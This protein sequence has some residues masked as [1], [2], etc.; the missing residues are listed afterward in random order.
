MKA[1]AHL[2]LGHFSEETARWI[3]GGFLFITMAI[4]PV[5][6]TA[7]L[8]F[9]LRKV[10]PIRKVGIINLAVA[11]GVSLLILPGAVFHRAEFSWLRWLAA[12]SFAICW[13]MCG[14]GLLSR[15]R[16]AWCGSIVGSGVLLCFLVATFSAVLAITIYPAEETLNS[17]PMLAGYVYSRMLIFV[18]LCLALTVSFWLFFGLLRIRRDIFSGGTT[19]PNTWLERTVMQKRQAI[20]TVGILGA[21]FI[22]IFAGIVVFVLSGEPPHDVALVQQFE[23]NR[24]VFEELRDM[25]EEDVRSHNISEVARWGLRTPGQGVPRSPEEE[26]MSKER[27]Q[28]YLALMEKA[29]IGACIHTGS[30]YRFTVAGSGFAGSGFRIAVTWNTNKPSP[31]IANLD[32]FRKNGGQWEQ[33]YRPLQENWYLWIIW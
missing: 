13:L 7:A 18:S 1:I 3:I 2:V 20:R 5:I 25:L 22:T 14:I 15:K 21:V 12:A 10:A 30:D 17:G 27:Y 28:K 26:G 6:I 29:G 19:M 9:G 16:I 32:N 33:G 31:I 8:F 23:A 11:S 24:G 4:V